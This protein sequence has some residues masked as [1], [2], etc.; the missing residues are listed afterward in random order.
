MVG[1][2]KIVGNTFTINATANNVALPAGGGATALLLQV[3]AA[4]ANITVGVYNSSA[5]TF[6]N[7]ATITLPANTLLVLE[8]NAPDVV[9][10]TPNTVCTPVARS[11]SA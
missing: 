7:I 1:S 6:A 2:I 10:S 5:N 9:Y 11:S 3:G 4:A 8:K